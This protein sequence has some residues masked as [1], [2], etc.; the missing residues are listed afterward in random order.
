MQG[1]TEEY[2]AYL[3]VKKYIRTPN[4]RILDVGMGNGNV[5]KGAHEQLG[6]DVFG[7]DIANYLHIN[8]KKK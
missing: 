3:F 6:A 8:N 2:E 7:I 4:K 1:N 5:L